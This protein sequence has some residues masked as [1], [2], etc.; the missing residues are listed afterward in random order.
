M[1]IRVLL[2]LCQ[3]AVFDRH[4]HSGRDSSSN[5]RHVIIQMQW[6]PLDEDWASK[7]RFQNFISRG[8]EIFS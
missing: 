3:I 7:T 4:L 1:A 8:D 6:S 2:P 5:G